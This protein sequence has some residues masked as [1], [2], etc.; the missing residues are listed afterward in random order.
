MSN[1]KNSWRYIRR[2]P[3][4]AFAAISIMLLTFIATGLF[5]LLSIGSARVLKYFEQKPQIIIFFNDTKKEADIK[6]LET[7]LKNQEKIASVKYVS[8]ED[9]LN[10]YKEQFKKDPLLLEMV[11]ADILPASLEISAVKIDYLPELASSLKNETDIS[12]IVFPEDVIKLLTSW[13]NS[14]RLIGIIIVVFLG[15][16]SLL[17][18]ITV[19]GMKISLKREEIGILQLVGGTNW[20][21]RG[22][23]VLEGIFYGVL[24][25]IIGSL[26]N[27]GWLVYATPVLSNLFVGI[28]I[29]P[30]PV[31]FYAV[32]FT[33]MLCLGAF[34]GAAASLL[35]I[36]RYLR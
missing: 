13:T 6:A 12:D 18:V 33:G 31:I 10:I 8:K 30:I 23:F 4:Q 20:Y 19:I 28:P 3:Y 22:P 26:I 9:A 35:A 25:A 1:I 21:I 16:V 5:V 14:I 7:T 24:G 27:I 2:S 15:F 34:L 29:F 32:F 36:N 11:S 17:T